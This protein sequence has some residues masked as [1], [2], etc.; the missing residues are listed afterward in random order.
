M[1][2]LANNI[3]VSEVYA[4]VLILLNNWFD[5]IHFLQLDLCVSTYISICIFQCTGTKPPLLKSGINLKTISPLDH[6]LLLLLCIW[7]VK[8]SVILETL[9][10][11]AKRMVS[12]TYSVEFVSNVVFAFSYSIISLLL[13]LLSAFFYMPLCCFSWTTGLLYYISDLR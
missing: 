1:K 8:V 3:G 9:I 5:W 7:L 12:L 2:R 11:L 10:S 6:D 13:C 4:T